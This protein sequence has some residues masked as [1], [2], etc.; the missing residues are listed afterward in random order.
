MVAFSRYRATDATGEGPG[1][2]LLDWLRHANKSLGGDQLARRQ[3]CVFCPGLTGGTE[4]P[5]QWRGATI[6]RVDPVTAAAELK[7]HDDRRKRSKAHLYLPLAVLHWARCPP[8]PGQEPRPVDAGPEAS[9]GSSSGP[10]AAAVRAS[11]SKRQADGSFACG[12]RGSS[13]DVDDVEEEELRGGCWPAA[14]AAAAGAAVDMLM[15]M[16]DQ[17]NEHDLAQL[18][19]ALS[20][21]APELMSGDCAPVVTGAAAGRASHLPQL[22]QLQPPCSPAS[23]QPS[24]GKRSQQLEIAG[25]VSVM[26]EQP[27]QYRQQVAK[28]LRTDSEMMTAAYG[29]MSLGVNRTGSSFSGPQQAAAAFGC[30]SE[31][32]PAAASVCASGAAAAAG[33]YQPP[34]GTASWVAPPS[35][36][37]A[38]GAAAASSFRASSGPTTLMDNSFMLVCGRGSGSATCAINLAAAPVAAASGTAPGGTVTASSIMG[39]AEGGASG[40]SGWGADGQHGTAAAA[41]SGMYRS[42]STS[43]SAMSGGSSLL[44]ATGLGGSSSGLGHMVAPSPPTGLSPSPSPPPG[45][46]LS[47]LQTEQQLRKMQPLQHQ[48]LAAA[49]ATAPGA[50]EGPVVAFLRSRSSPTAPAAGPAAGVPAA[51]QQVRARSIMVPGPQAFVAAESADAGTVAAAATA[52]A[53]PA[54][55]TQAQPQQ[56]SASWAA[57]AQPCSNVLGADNELASLF[58]EIEQCPWRPSGAAAE[59]PAGVTPFAW[60]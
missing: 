20:H 50:A 17:D 21:D 36:R 30:T 49:I 5:N 12:G 56:L 19:R 60:Q 6:R 51:L 44:L 48:Q 25:V 41:S 4:Q 43:G 54:Q 46:L 34:N 38:S 52:R 22:P 39:W 8:R 59:L 27:Q 55:L 47:R 16:D 11:P 10:G 2:P 18:H 3:I 28:M 40:H 23:S 9:A 14:A 13:V 31:E 58:A 45:P 1:L 26:M 29:Y 37:L 7:Y 32:L 53:A 24:F 42:R 57:S 15:M 33:A 35:G